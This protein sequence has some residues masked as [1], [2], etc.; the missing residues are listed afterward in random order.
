[1]F[2]STTLSKCATTI[3]IRAT[4]PRRVTIQSNSYRSS[5]YSNTAIT[6]QM[7]TSI[8]LSVI[9]SMRLLFACSKE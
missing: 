7:N 6:I 3:K 5:N 9:I 8:L 4:I 2:C 1:M